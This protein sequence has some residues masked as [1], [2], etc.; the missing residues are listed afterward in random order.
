[1]TP[2]ID[3]GL[4]VDFIDR[5]K[6][7]EHLHLLFDGDKSLT[8]SESDQLIQQVKEMSAKYPICGDKIS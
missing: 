1:M 3:D 2:V 5:L 6:R 7:G 8:K 4:D